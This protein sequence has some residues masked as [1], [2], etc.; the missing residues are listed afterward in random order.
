MISKLSASLAAL[1]LLLSPGMAAAQDNTPDTAAPNERVLQVGGYL[2]NLSTQRMGALMESLGFNLPASDMGP[3]AEMFAASIPY[4][5]SEEAT[6]GMLDVIVGFGTK[7]LDA[8]PPTEDQ[9]FQYSAGTASALA[10]EESQFENTQGYDL[11]RD[12]AA[13][14][15]A[16]PQGQVAYFRHMTLDDAE[17]HQCVVVTSDGAGSWKIQSRSLAAASDLRLRSY[18]ALQLTIAGRDDWVRQLGDERR[19]AVVAVGRILADHALAI[20]RLNAD[21]VPAANNEAA[22]ERFRTDV[23]RLGTEI[24]TRQE[25]AT[26]D[27]SAD[28]TSAN[29]IEQTKAAL[30]GLAQKLG[31]D[32]P[33]LEIGLTGQM[34]QASFAGRWREGLQ[35]NRFTSDYVV[36]DRNGPAPERPQDFHLMPDEAACRSV[37]EAGGRM[38]YFRRLALDGVAEGHQC[39][40]AWPRDD[41]TAWTLISHSVSV[42]SDVAVLSNYS[43]TIT[44][45]AGTDAARQFGEEGQDR[46]VAVAT[47]LADYGLAANAAKAQMRATEDPEN[48]ARIMA[49]FR[50]R[51]RAGAAPPAA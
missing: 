9:T 44:A 41:G 24:T 8:P 46:M 49:R 6:G 47:L 14:Q 30:V 27:V 16:H 10:Q 50:E 26:Y 33:D 37:L 43:M 19:D 48:R 13:C 29:Y 34:V 17:G 20:A 42:A 36:W 2:S 3:S 11:Y 23:E 21:T 35:G 31:I 28:E 51:L 40:G 38:V 25:A 15:A 39:V 4:S 12:E 5:D 32:A 7:R 18:Y 1:A 45:D 22:L